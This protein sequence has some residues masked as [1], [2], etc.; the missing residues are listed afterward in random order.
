M[1]GGFIYYNSVTKNPFTGDNE[2]MVEVKEGHSFYDVI[3]TLDK[4]G[5]IKNTTL[6]KL[7]IKLKDL[8]VKLV[9]GN[10]KIPTNSTM[11]EFIAILESPDSDESTVSV[12]I[13]EGYD[14]ES[15]AKLFEE[16][17]LFSK[18]EFTKAVKEFETPN[19]ISKVDGQKYAME[20]FLFPDTYKIVK[21]ETPTEVISMMNK[22]F[23]EIIKDVA[24]S[25]QKEIKDIYRTVSMASIVER[26]AVA[27][28]ER[29]IVASVFYNRL[30]INMKFQ[31]CATVLYSLGEY[32]EKL[33]EKDLEVQSP[34]NTYLVD[35]YPIGP[36]CSPGKSSLMAAVNPQDTNYL[37]FVA[38]NDGTH[39]FTDDYSE[40]LKVKEKTQGF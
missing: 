10:F 36:I 1:L 27:E 33:Y 32:K 34:Y 35:G 7:Y 29:P 19:Y 21:G 26:E 13:P 39:F 23:D 5:N 14:I 2:F 15:M 30:E 22:R 4:T 3:Y 25:S 24:E 40:F 8:N 16:K 18:D 6:S 31:S 12:T 11:E 37:Y 28:G 38:N 20:G 9:P 17:G